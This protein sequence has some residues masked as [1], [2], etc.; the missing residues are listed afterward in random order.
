MHFE[1]LILYFEI[2]FVP[3][4]QSIVTTMQQEVT[5][6]FKYGHK[7]WTVYSS[8][9]W[10][11]ETLERT[12]HLGDILQMQGFFAHKITEITDDRIV[13]EFYEE[14]YILTRDE[15]IHMFS[16]IEG[17]EWSDG[18]V[19]DGDDYSIDLTWIK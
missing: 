3:L 16:E 19:Y 10:E 7:H 1:F 2:F 18:C 14:K 8:S 5:L 12:Y 6:H 11:Y 15:P 4:H 9:E 17:R 13:I